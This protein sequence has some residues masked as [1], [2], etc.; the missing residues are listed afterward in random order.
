MTIFK[1]S[2]DASHIYRERTAANTTMA[3][4]SSVSG[5]LAE[6]TKNATVVP[7]RIVILPKDA[8]V[9]PIELLRKN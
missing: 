1:T 7:D 2:A 5:C 6:T 9:I 4:S 3:N 8:V